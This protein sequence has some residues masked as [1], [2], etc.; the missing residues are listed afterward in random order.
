MKNIFKLILILFVGMLD[1][2]AQNGYPAKKSVTFGI[3]VAV[4]AAGVRGVAS[5]KPKVGI[6]SGITIKGALKQKVYLKSGL[7][8]AFQGFGDNVNGVNAN[9][10]FGYFQVPVMIQYYLTRSV[11]LELG[12]QVGYLLFAEIGAKDYD[13]QDISELFDKLD[14]SGNAGVGIKLDHEYNLFVRY[15]YGFSKVNKYGNGHLQNYFIMLG[16]TLDF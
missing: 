2:Y 1:T 13:S 12:P 15:S 14:I 9:I 10:N 5:L 16:L 8:L 7:N 3:D 6:L 11:Y 4:G